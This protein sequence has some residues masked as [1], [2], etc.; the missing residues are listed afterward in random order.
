MTKQERVSNGKKTVSSANGVW[1][2]RQPHTEE[3]TW[4]TVLHHTQMKKLLPILLKL[5]QKIE[6]DGK[7]L[8]SFYNTSIT[9][10]DSTKKELQTNI[11]EDDI[12]KISH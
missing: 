6:M 10:K 4:T 7:L 2:T 5:F 8:N 12:C 1:K 9:L 11:P 3:L